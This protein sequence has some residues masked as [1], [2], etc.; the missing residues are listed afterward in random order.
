MKTILLSSLFAA[1]CLVACSSSADADDDDTSSSSSGG[2][3]GA[4]TSSGGSSG[5]GGGECTAARAEALQEQSSVT[6]GAVSSLAPESGEGTW[7]Y[8]D[9][10][11]G[12]AG[13]AASKPRVYVNLE[14]L[15][16]VDVSDVDAQSSTDW[17]LAIK[18][19]NVFTNGGVGGPGEGGAKE[20]KKSFEDVTAADATDI[21]SEAFFNDDCELIMKDIGGQPDPYTFESTMSGWY[22]YDMQGHGVT[23]R[24]TT[25]IV[26]GGAGALYKVK[27]EKYAANPDGSKGETTARFLLRVAPL[28]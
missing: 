15:E 25:F 2:S 20:I 16:R 21:A 10:S 5:G 9:A 6:T 28:P 24:D 27:F 17:D 1:V 14:R 23:P 26:K 3:S 8:V 7:L 13:P 12:G 22:D 11:A 19:T 18:R 4:S